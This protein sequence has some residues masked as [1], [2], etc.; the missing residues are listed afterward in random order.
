MQKLKYDSEKNQSYWICAK[1]KN[2]VPG[3]EAWYDKKTD[4]QYHFNC[5]PKKNSK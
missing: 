3:H 4:K 2:P 1:C 5:L